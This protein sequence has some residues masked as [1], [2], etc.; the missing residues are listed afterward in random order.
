M[1]HEEIGNNDLEFDKLIE[2][3]MDLPPDQLDDVLAWWDDLPAR[4]P[5]SEEELDK[6]ERDIATHVFRRIRQLQAPSN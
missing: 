4:R 2:L 6:L 5:L 3:S 1:P